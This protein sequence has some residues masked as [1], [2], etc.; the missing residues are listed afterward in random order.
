MKSELWTGWLA[1]LKHSSISYL[2]ALVLTDVEKN[3]HSE[4]SE[5]SE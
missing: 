1:V 4:M 2:L 5:A 3:G